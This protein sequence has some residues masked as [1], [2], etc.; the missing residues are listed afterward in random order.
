[1]NYPMAF[2]TNRNNIKLVFRFVTV[3]MVVLLCLFKTIKTLQSTYFSHFTCPDS[4]L[5]SPFCS[6]FIWIRNTVSC[7]TVFTIFALPVLFL[8]GICAI[9]TRIIIAITSG[10]AF[11]KFRNEFNLLAATASSCYN[12]FRHGF[13]LIKKLCLEPL[14]DRF[15][16]GSLYFSV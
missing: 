15:L 14:Q 8:V 5:H 10:L 9:F 6:Y 1:M 2:F 3:P 13:F 12:R 11:V 16:C 7:A 4:I